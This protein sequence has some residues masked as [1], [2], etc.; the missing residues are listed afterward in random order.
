MINSIYLYIVQT[1]QLS[2]GVCEYPFKLF[3][4]PNLIYH[5]A[6][7]LYTI[8][9]INRLFYQQLK[10]GLPITS[11]VQQCEPPLPVITRDLYPK[12]LQGCLKILL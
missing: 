4:I 7:L 9:S 3:T 6:M 5:K 8:K 1:K 2:T 12:V 11:N 10:T